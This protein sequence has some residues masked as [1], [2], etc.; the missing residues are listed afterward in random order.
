MGTAC[1]RACGLDKHW[2]SDG[3]ARLSAKQRRTRKQKPQHP[4][5]ED[6]AVV[7]AKKFHV[8]IDKGDHGV[9]GVRLVAAASSQ[10]DAAE[11]I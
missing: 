8:A 1:T 9:A 4:K 2:H 10:T 7:R 5:H 3:G 11:L 6:F